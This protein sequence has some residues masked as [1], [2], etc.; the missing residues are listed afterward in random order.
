MKAFLGQATRSSGNGPSSLTHYK[1]DTN[2][3][4]S[5][6]KTYALENVDKNAR[7]EPR[8][9]NNNSQVFVLGSGVRPR[10]SKKKNIDNSFVTK[11][12]AM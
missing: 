3:H 11:I 7:Q 6:A 8:E 12:K 4:I 9:D 5:A 2:T 1:T 10:P